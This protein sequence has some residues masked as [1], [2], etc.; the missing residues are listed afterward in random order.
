MDIVLLKT[1]LEVSK[2]R[3][4]GKAAERL[5]ITQSAVSARIKLLETSLGVE[6]FERKRNDIQ[7]TVAGQRLSRHAAMIVNGWERARQELSLR[8]GVSEA[9]AIGCTHD[10][11]SIAL[12]SMLRRLEALQ[13]ALAL[14][15]EVHS[16][17]TLI[18]RLNNGL[19]DL[20]LVFEPPMLPTLVARQIARVPLQLVAAKKGISVT[21]AMGKDYVYVDWGVSFDLS[22]ARHFADIPPPAIRTGQGSLALDILLDRGGAAYLAQQMVEPALAAGSL[23]AVAEAPI[24]E[25]YSYAVYRTDSEEK[26]ALQQVLSAAVG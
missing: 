26:T 17:E 10:L 11:W 3:H 5:F 23:F 16:T 15:V 21:Q 12:R 14:S 24:I 1:F 18:N 4:F 6:L 9:L 2:T 25:R 8:S 19:L 22:H 7:L 20:V 13:P